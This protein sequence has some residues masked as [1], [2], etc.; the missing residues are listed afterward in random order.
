MN[1]FLRLSPD[2]RFSAYR[3]VEEAMNLQ[4]FSVEKDFRVCWTRREPSINNE[5]TV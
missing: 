3:Q 1:D 2:E 4:S 5:H